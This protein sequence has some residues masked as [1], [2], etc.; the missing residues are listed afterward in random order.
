MRL[1]I[2]LAIFNNEPG[3]QATFSRSLAG[4]RG[5]A[6]FNSGDTS[7]MVILISGP[8]VNG[9]LWRLSLSRHSSVANQSHLIHC[10][11]KNR[12][13]KTPG[14]VCRVSKIDLASRAAVAITSR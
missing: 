14:L 12:S 5:S 6:E 13:R 9:G 1:V 8:E 10:F 7:A 11:K 2:G 4:S 3:E